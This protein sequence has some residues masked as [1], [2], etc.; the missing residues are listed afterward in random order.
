MKYKSCCKIIKYTI[1]FVLYCILENNIKAETH[2]TL[3]SKYLG[4]IKL[5]LN[6]YFMDYNA[7]L[8]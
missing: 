2:P 5:A 4:S 8:Q 3:P 7:F 1:W 6:N